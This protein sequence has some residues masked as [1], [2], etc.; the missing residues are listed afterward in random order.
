MNSSTLA[1]AQR[2][3]SSDSAQID[4]TVERYIP[5]LVMEPSLMF[6]YPT[7]LVDV[8]RAAI[9]HIHLPELK[10]PSVTATIRVVTGTTH[11]RQPQSLRRKAVSSVSTFLRSPSTLDCSH[12][13]IFDARWE[14]D[15]HI[16]HIIDNVATAVLYAQ[17]VLSEHF[18]RKIQITVVLRKNASPLGRQV[19]ET[20]GIPAI[21]TDDPVYGDVVT[22]EAADTLHSIQQEAF[23]FE[24]KG[25]TP[26]T[27]ER[28][29][30]PRRGNRGLINN[31][32]V[33]DFL[34]QRGFTTY[35]FEDLT[36]S[37][38]WSIARNAKV[39]VAVHG[40]ACSNFIFNRPNSGLRLVEIFS[41]G[42]M[43]PGYR[44][45]APLM[46][47]KWCGV[48]GQITPAI[49]QEIDF[50]HKP[51]NIQKA[52]ISNSIRVSLGTLDLALD[53]L[54]VV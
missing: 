49:L 36:P 39:I 32:E 17:K 23:N 30:I 16:G 8:Y 45:V 6:A 2:S 10:Y 35:Y 22:V 14:L 1:E 42:F 12:Q 33:V 38:E 31:D 40:A 9:E 11:Q 27:P 53:Y 13:F 51:R 15:G 26:D 29:F 52:P 47:G 41:P 24:F 43:L 37:Q 5:G 28:I 25:Y 21:Y 20:M 48:R 44:H 46:Q 50:S 4:L 34:E 7:C 18:D 19:Y 54:N 3:T